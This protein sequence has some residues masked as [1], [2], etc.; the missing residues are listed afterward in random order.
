MDFKLGGSMATK[1]K[2]TAAT[3]DILVNQGADYRLQLRLCTG[4]KENHTPI[5]ITGYVFKCKIRETADSDETLAEADAHIVDA[6]NGLME[7]F[8]DDS[9]TGKIETDG[10]TYEIC[11][12]R[13]RNRARRR[14]HPYHEWH[15]LCKPRSF[16]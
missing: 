13:I 3:K 15:L 14:Y 4:T 11:L 1:I 8:F 10:Q 7:V 16:F 2:Q 5:D 9:I 6:E 12:G